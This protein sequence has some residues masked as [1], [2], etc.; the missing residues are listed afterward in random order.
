MS[1]ARTRRLLDAWLDDELDPATRAEIAGHLAQLPELRCAA[2][3][4]ASD[5]VTRSVRPICA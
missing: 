5:C 4:R 1:C 3:P 2:S